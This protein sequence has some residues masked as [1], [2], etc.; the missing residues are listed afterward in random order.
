[1]MKRRHRA[2]RLSQSLGRQRARIYGRFSL[3]SFLWWNKTAAAQIS[4]S[5]SGRC[6]FAPHTK[7]EM[8]PAM[9]Q[10]TAREIPSQ[11]G[12]PARDQGGYLISKTVARSSPYI[13]KSWRSFTTASSARA[14]D[15]LP[16]FNPL[17]AAR[18]QLTVLTKWTDWCKTNSIKFHRPLKQFLRLYI[19]IQET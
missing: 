15:Q 12:R 3:L 9:S 4:L 14:D 18:C 16:P 19:I 7:R 2:E 6:P 8:A 17:C 5:L 1:M 11:P 10:F 13:G